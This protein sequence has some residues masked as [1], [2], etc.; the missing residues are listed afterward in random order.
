MTELFLLLLLLSIG[1]GLIWLIV[2]Q[3]KQYNQ[4][5][6]YRHKIGEAGSNV[7]VI[8]QKRLDLVNQLAAVAYEYVR[9]E[10]PLLASI[11]RSAADVGDMQNAA[12]QVSAAMNRVVMLSQKYP[13]LLSNQRFAQLMSEEARVE[14]QL[15]ERREAYNDVVR[16]FNT[17]RGRFPTVLLASLLGLAEAPYWRRV[18]HES[19]FEIR[20]YSAPGIPG[21]AGGN[22]RGG[23]AE[24]EISIDTL[25]Q[26]TSLPP[27]TPNRGWLEV[28][29]G[30]T[31]TPTVAIRDGLV[32]GRDEDVDMHLT[33]TEVSR[34][35]AIIYMSG[36]ALFLEDQDSVNGTYVNGKPVTTIRLQDGDRIEVGDADLVFKAR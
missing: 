12:A 22:S 25:A 15:Q 13:E 11:G 34:R 8:L 27:N 9:V 19:G 18:P 7:A 20:P 36:G 24:E 35:H 33:G 2:T 30:S 5:H 3:I 23:Q 16:K 31:D 26:N 29:Q 4:L 6:E 32:I 10:V 14:D 28:L 17:T 21:S 1:F